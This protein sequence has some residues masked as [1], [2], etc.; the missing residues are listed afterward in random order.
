MNE[1][2]LSVCAILESHV[3]VAAV[4]DTCK[5]NDDIV[6]GDFNVSLNLEDHLCGGYEPN[7]AK[8]EFK[9]CMQKIEVMNVNATG[10]YFTW[11]QKPKGSSGILNKIDRIMCNIPFTNDF[12]G[13]LPIFQPYR[14]SDH[15]PCV[16]RIP[17]NLN[18]NA[19]AMYR[20]VKRLKG[21]ETPLHKL[22]HDQGNLHDRVNRL[23][24]E[25]DEA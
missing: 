4:Y 18:V 23:R 13:S 5:K 24:V 10:L 9:E 8:R 17:K 16:L 20:V 3:Y 7:I 22:L 19:C 25:L 21:L 6:D 2:N 1:N 14:I 12:S 11:N 15:S